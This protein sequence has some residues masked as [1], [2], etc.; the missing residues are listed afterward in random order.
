MDIS[1]PLDRINKIY[2]I[3]IRYKVNGIRFK[4]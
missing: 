2:R 3:K 4:V 1:K